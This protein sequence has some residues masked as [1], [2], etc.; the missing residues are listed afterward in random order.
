[1][2]I[3]IYV[4]TSWA[5]EACQCPCSPHTPHTVFS[6][7]T[8]VSCVWHDASVR[9]TWRIHM[10][11]HVLFI[12]V[13]WRICMFDMSHS[14]VWNGSFICVPPFHRRVHTCNTPATHLQ[15]TPATHLQH[16]CNTP[17]THLQHTAT[18][19]NT[20]Q[21]TY[22]TLRH[23][24][25]KGLLCNPFCHTQKSQRHTYEWSMCH[26]WVKYNKYRWC[27]VTQMNQAC[28]TYQ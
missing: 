18:H 16:T 10:Y 12:C 20:L 26:T 8:C 1:M 17:A 2:Y 11:S 13:K 19:C 28:H 9:V 22:S 7:N 6:S 3:Y 27:H 14:H 15:H 25:I 5:H 21:H 24:V 23:T 4:H